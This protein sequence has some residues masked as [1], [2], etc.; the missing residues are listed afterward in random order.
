VNDLV[1]EGL[2]YH[3]I[4]RRLGISLETVKTAEAGVLEVA[5]LSN[6]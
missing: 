4:A 6:R 5:L 2:S 1:R 3:E